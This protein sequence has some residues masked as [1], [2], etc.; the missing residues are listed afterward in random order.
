VFNFIVK[1]IMR[2]VLKV[3][4]PAPLIGM[5]IFFFSMA[6]MQDNDAA[7]FVEFFEPG[8]VLL[9]QFLPVFF[10][11]GLISTPRAA[12]GIRLL[13]VLKFASIVVIGMTAILFEVGHIV[14]L[15]MKITKKTPPEPLPPKFG[16]FVPWFSEDVEI[17]FGALTGLTGLL[18]YVVPALQQSF[19][20]FTTVFSFIIASRLPRFM[21]PKVH[22]YWHPLMTTYFA[23]TVIFILQGLPRGKGLLAVLHEYLVPGA[24]WDKAGGNFIMFFLEPAIISFSFGLFARKQLLGEH[25]ASILIG[26]FASAFLGILTMAAV[27][28][29]VGLPRTLALA[30]MPRATAALAVVQ[31]GMIGASAAL[32]TIHC[33]IIGI[34]GANFG[35]PLLDAMGFKNPI[36]R[37]I[38]TGGSGLAL[39]AAALAQA[40]PAA[41]PFG[42]LTM[43]LTSTFATVLFSIP[44]F[45]R[46]VFWIG[47]LPRFEKVA[48]VV[49]A[50]TVK[51]LAAADK[52]DKV[53][54]VLD[55]VKGAVE[56]VKDF[57]LD[58]PKK[59]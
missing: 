32:T 54:E 5:V 48:E 23:T 18:A 50:V 27:T 34:S 37:G 24:T 1:G 47:G 41:F 46:L 10:I 12:T 25:A 30:L 8:V 59:R 55:N 58:L 11:P 15:V 26:S 38:A 36:A 2:N 33:C 49:E 9:T 3:N 21:P 6:N 14:E 56:K 17:I 19:Y 57:I 7:K 43:S 28:R 13:D 45:Q 20:V 39:A 40:D 51:E 4:F 22:K 44:S 16:K 29:V 52:V 42:T 31:A 35:P 53:K